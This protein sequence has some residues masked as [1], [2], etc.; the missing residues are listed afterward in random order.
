MPAEFSGIER[1]LQRL[2]ES[3]QRLEALQD[4][5]LTDFLVSADLRDIAERNLEVAAQ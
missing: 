2:D 4:L 5:P 3:V 1:R